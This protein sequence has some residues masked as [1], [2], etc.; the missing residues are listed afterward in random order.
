[1]DKL[2]VI[3]DF[4][5]DFILPEGALSVPRASS[6]ISPLENYLRSLPSQPNPP[7]TILITLDT[8]RQEEY[9]RG[10]ESKTYPLH[11]KPGQ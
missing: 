6:L 3:V 11:C 8:H 5:N 9:F 4:Q 10:E 7:S 1:M 2:L